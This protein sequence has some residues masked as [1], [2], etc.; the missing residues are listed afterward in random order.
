[1]GIKLVFIY[2]PPASGKLTVARRL[3]KLT[4][5]KLYHNHVSIQFVTSLFE[6]GTETFHRLI[7]K[8]RKEMMEEAARERIDTIFT[9]VYE[10][11]ADDQFIREII[12]RVKRHDGKLLFVRL[13]CN[14]E[15][16]ARRIGRPDRRALGK[17]TKE[18]IL[19]DLFRGHDLDSEIP[20]GSSL[21]IDTAK[22]GP[23]SAAKMIIQHYKLPLRK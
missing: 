16:L 5:F 15:E 4:G 1:M 8:Y 6:F 23:T 18:R 21:S 22:H 11:K 13:H 2:G 7:D 9:F 17:L 20:F 10:S 14:R 3:A 12:K 19:D